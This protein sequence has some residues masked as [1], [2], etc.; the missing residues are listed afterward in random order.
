MF[1]GFLEDRVL[2]SSEVAVPP[3]INNYE[4]EY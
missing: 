4:L 3:A 2:G 1:Q